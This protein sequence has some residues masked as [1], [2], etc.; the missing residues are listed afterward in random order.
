MVV[1]CPSCG[2]EIF[3][4]P[5]S[6][7]MCGWKRGSP[8]P[9]DGRRGPAQRPP[10]QRAQQPRYQQ[11]RDDPRYQRAPRRA[12]DYPP[13]QRSY[14]ERQRTQYPPEAEGYYQGMPREDPRR[15]RGYPQRYRAEPQGPPPQRRDQREYY[16]N[17]REEPYQE[18]RGRREPDP[19]YRQEQVRRA[20]QE[21][22][23]TGL[24]DST[25]NNCPNCGREIFSDP[26]NCVLCGW[27]RTREERQ[28]PP[29][30]DQRRGYPMRRAQGYP[31]E[32]QR[33]YPP[34][35]RGR[36][37][38]ERR[39]GREPPLKREKRGWF[40]P[41]TQTKASKKDGTKDRFRCEN[42]QNP[43]LQFFADG[44]GR[45]PGCGH[46]F[47]YSQRPTTARAKQKHKQFICSNCDA[48][49]LQFFLDGTGLC[50]HCRREFKWSKG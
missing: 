18:R 27:S 7:V 23:G 5:D 2:R 16:D 32:E 36:Q 38:E 26:N 19:R 35:G 14:P 45:C 39:R 34:E 33:R 48:K 44:L 41:Q 12:P 21:A 1:L 17:R 49:N 13:Q 6:C 11:P 25:R 40:Q 50:P 9:R 8:P 42:C 28:S 46:R 10:P 37:F 29:S 31:I 47:R 43:S 4:D 3:S 15:Q 22:R 24:G 20:P 30:D